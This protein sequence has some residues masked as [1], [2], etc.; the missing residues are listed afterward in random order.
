MTHSP[1]HSRLPLADA[2]CPG[3]RA[4]WA[5]RRCVHRF[6]PLHAFWWAERVCCKL[7]LQRPKVQ[8]YAISGLCVRTFQSKQFAKC[9]VPLPRSP[10]IIPDPVWRTNSCVQYVMCGAQD[11]L[12]D[13][14]W[15][16]N[17]SVQFVKQHMYKQT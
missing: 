7:G 17:R 1:M 5:H 13:P 16:T 8:V 4:A 14:F 10:L 2:H 6:Q 12:R 9:P 11:F 3:S 15:Y